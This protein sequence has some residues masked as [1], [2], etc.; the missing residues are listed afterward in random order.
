MI[1]LKDYR[2][3]T[4]IGVT[5]MNATYPKEE[6]LKSRKSIDFLFAEGSSVAR[7]PLRLA[8]IEIPET[9]D[10][11]FGVSVSKKYFKRAVDR[12]YI[13]RLMR[14]IYRKNKGLLAAPDNRKFHFML[15]YQSREMPAF[16]PLNIKAL[17]LFEKF[18]KSLPDKTVET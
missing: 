6:K 11:K 15:L 9:E 12:N 16:E 3:H 5:G 8:F 1:K 4:C 17:E 2:I 10:S 13:K 14:E 18:L 7:F